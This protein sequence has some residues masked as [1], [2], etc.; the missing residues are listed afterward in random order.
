MVMNIDWETTPIKV[1]FRSFSEAKGRLMNCFFSMENSSGGLK[2]LIETSIIRFKYLDKDSF[3]CKFRDKSKDLAIFSDFSAL[4][5]IPREDKKNFPPKYSVTV[6]KFLLG[7]LTDEFFLFSIRQNIQWC[8][9]C[10]N[11]HMLNTVQ[12]ELRWNDLSL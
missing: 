6:R 4:L 12:G 2:L 1:F 5:T 7:V 8:F 9:S 10:L 3:D 11:F